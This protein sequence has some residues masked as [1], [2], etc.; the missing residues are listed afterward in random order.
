MGMDLLIGTG[1]LGQQLARSIDRKA[2]LT[3]RFGDQPK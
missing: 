3:R 1:R 2:L